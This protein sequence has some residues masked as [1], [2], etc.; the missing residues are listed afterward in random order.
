MIW[1]ALL[2]GAIHRAYPVNV[3]ALFTKWN[4]RLEDKSYFIQVV[5]WEYQHLIQCLS[6]RDHTAISYVGCVHSVNS[7]SSAANIDLLIRTIC[8]ERKHC[9]CYYLTNSSTYIELFY[10]YS[11]SNFP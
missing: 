4:I 6:G 11:F 10:L 3:M 1:G 8:T 2:R 5:N 9:T 7:G